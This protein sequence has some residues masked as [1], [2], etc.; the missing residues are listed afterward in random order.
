VLARERVELIGDE[1]PR[2]PYHA[3][4]DTTLARGKALVAD[5][6]QAAEQGATEALHA[7]ATRLRADGHDVIGVAIAI[8]KTDLPDD[9]AAILS[10]HTRV[11][12][13]EG[14]LF[15]N[16]LVEG[17]TQAGLDVTRFANHAA[18]AD[19]A[20]ALGIATDALTTR[21]TVLGKP[22]GPP[23]RKDHREAAAAALL[24]LAA[25]R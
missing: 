6:E 13:A 19:A 16:A 3:A 1:L 14:E 25:G 22:L 12:T 11:H 9:L 5:V 18:I 2:M 7:L 4:I 20:A 21:L 15:R 17:A 23:W 10:S 8:G 24:V